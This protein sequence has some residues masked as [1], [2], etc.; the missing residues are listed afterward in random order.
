MATMKEI[1]ELSGV[2]RGTVDRV[3]NHRGS[4]HPQTAKRIMEIA[5]ALNYQ[6]N[7]AGLILAAQ[8]KNLKIG[9][10]L[11]Q[12]ANPFFQE[13]LKGVHAK[14]EELSGYNCKALIR[15]VTFG[16]KCQKYAME[17][18]LQ[19][20]IHGL[21]IS[22]FNGKEIAE[23][24][25]QFSESGI[26][27]ITTN[28][29]IASRRI[30]YVGSNYYLSGQTAAGLLGRMTFGQT[31]VGIINGSSHILCHTQRIA[32]FT[33]TI[34]KFY[35]HIKISG[36]VENHDDD[37]ESYEKTKELLIRRPGINALYFTA[38]GVFGGCQAVLSL[39]LSEKIKIFTY[40][41]VKTTAE[42]VKDGVITATICQ[43]PFLQGY[44]PLE[45]LSRYLLEG[46]LPEK[47][48]YYT[49]IDIRIRE[50]I[51]TD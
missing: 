45:L 43:Q 11:F 1:A 48:F 24:I 10:I 9:V 19:E 22:P 30:A 13:V 26:P 2:S 33:E 28:T 25:N 41:N 15:Q 32:G 12:D 47:E 35:P 29:D 37:R 42:L 51:E 6:P 4:V 8:K 16:E 7:K 39:G 38:A 44:R 18:L 23:K 17:E 40:D 34:R 49:D 46:I 21:V 27:V 31:E 50:N 5:Q 36:I 3:L 14:A 20:K